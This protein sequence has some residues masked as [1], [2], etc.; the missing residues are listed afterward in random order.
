MRNPARSGT[1]WTSTDQSGTKCLGTV[2]TPRLGA[3]QSAVP[4]P[5]LWDHAG[6]SATPTLARSSARVVP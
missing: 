5:A 4:P 1:V 2:N 3:V 6:K